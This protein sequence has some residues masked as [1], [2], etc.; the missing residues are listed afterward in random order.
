[1]AGSAIGCCGLRFG[2]LSVFGLAMTLPGKQGRCFTFFEWGAVEVFAGGKLGT[3]PYFFSQK[4]GSCPHF[5]FSE[6]ALR[7]GG[8]VTR[9]ISNAPLYEDALP[10]ARMVDIGVIGQLRHRLYGL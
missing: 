8:M 10:P 5:P 2:R 4:I 7:C 3:A 1:M 6:K 9:K